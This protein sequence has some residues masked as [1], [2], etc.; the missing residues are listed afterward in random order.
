MYARYVNVPTGRPLDQEEIELARAR[1]DATALPRPRPSQHEPAAC[2]GGRRGDLLCPERPRR[3]V[4]ATHVSVG[5]LARRLHTN[6]THVSRIGLGVKMCYELC[7]N[8]LPD[9]SPP[10]ICVIGNRTTHWVFLPKLL[11]SEF[12]GVSPPT[13]LVSEG[14]DSCEREQFGPHGTLQQPCNDRI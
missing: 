12:Y 9:L 7:L 11:I 6:D 3:A 10:S 2:G 8:P 13:F 1:C 14:L 4:V 5:L